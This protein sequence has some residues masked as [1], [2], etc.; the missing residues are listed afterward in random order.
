MQTSHDLGLNLPA[1]SLSA[2]SSLTMISPPRDPEPSSSSSQ[3]QSPL[4]KLE[5]EL[6]KEEARFDVYGGDDPHEPPPKSPDDEEKSPTIAGDED[7]FLVTWEGLHDPQNPQ[8]WSNLYKWWLT[9]LCGIMT[10][11]V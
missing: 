7:V 6:E 9:I 3:P 1:T 11:N 5:R 2:R 8:N 10:V 4:D